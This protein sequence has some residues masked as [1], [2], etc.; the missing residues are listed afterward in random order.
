MNQSETVVVLISGAGY[1]NYGDDAILS[2]WLDV[3][4]NCDLILISGPAYKGHENAS[5]ISHFLM[6]DLKSCEPQGIQKLF[7]KLKID[8]AQEIKKLIANYEYAIVHIVGGGFCND[9]FGTAPKIFRLL[10]EL[11]PVASLVGTGISFVPLSGESLEE[12]KKLKF[13]YISF[14]DRISEYGCFGGFFPILCDDLLPEMASREALTPASE[15]TLFLNIQNQFG[16]C[17]QIKNIAKKI[18]T[19]ISQN[20]YKSVVLCE[21]CTGDLDI[22]TYLDDVQIMSRAEVYKGSLQPKQGDHFVGTRF[23]FRMLM[24]YAGATGIVIVVDNDYYSNKHEIDGQHTNFM[25]GCS[26]VKSISDFIQSDAVFPKWEMKTNN[27][28]DLKKSESGIIKSI[29]A[30]RKIA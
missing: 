28:V 25:S 12:L 21:L 8:A 15:K 29:I 13:K 9:K 18:K 6:H 5:I 19:I 7:A 14:R 3:Y 17:G 22:R 1:E 23:H 11:S 20:D 27:L 2:N 26:V 10:K 24:E 30:E 16:A 4:K